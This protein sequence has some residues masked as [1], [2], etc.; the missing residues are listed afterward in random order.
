MTLDVNNLTEQ[1][2]LPAWMEDAAREAYERAKQIQK[3][4]QA[5]EELLKYQDNPIGFCK[6]ILGMTRVTND[7]MDMMNSVNDSVVTLARSSNAVGKSY[8]AARLG[9][10]FYLCYPDSQ[11]YMTAAPPERNLINILWAHV[12][13]IV[14]QKPA[15]FTGHTIKRAKVSRS[16]DSFIEGVTIPLQG[17]S[18][19]REAK[20]SGKHAHHLM[21]IVDEGDAV[22]E[23]VY[24]GIESC[25]SSSHVKLLILFN[26]R[27]PQGKLFDM[28]ERGQAKICQLSAFNH[29]NVITGKDIIPGAVS[30]DV[31]LRRINEWTRPL[32]ADEKPDSECFE[33]PKF[34]VG[35]TTVANSGE[36]YSPLPAGWRKVFQ[37]EFWYKVL[38]KYPA[39]GAH[40]LIAPEAV[41]RAMERGRE[42]REK[43]GEIPP[44]GIKPILGLDC[45]EFGGDN[46]SLCARYGHYIPPIRTWGGLDA[47]Q[48]TDKTLELY[49][50][51]NAEIIFTDA[52]GVGSVVAPSI[53]RKGRDR[54]P[55][56]DVCAYGIKVSEK[57]SQMTHIDL[58]EF[59]SMRDELWWRVR[60][61]LLKDPNATL[62][63][64]PMLAQELKA[65]NYEYTNSVGKTG[66]KIKVMSKEKFRTILKRSCDRAD[67][68]CLTFVP[69][70]RATVM[71]LS[72]E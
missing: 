31:T 29:P 55:K 35:S 58:G 28:E 21:F 50:E 34:L 23:E 12:A 4:F 24:R 41:D 39:S 20:F 46:N 68:L 5:S 9:L 47:D 52:L 30:R 69:M 51:L 48:T 3:S 57:P 2:K 49:G 44:S 32:S 56:I 33:V 42:Y 53:V 60:E 43:Y 59:Y 71:R 27:A 13:T 38:A 18:E 25:M 19:A 14:K 10:W 72:G 22:P 26:P 17:T 16:P 36:I 54:N 11:V 45:A 66:G 65:A 63:D 7:L 15:L 40:Q 67:A 62:P 61:Y 37:D 70:A 64:D 6:D 1:K 8:S